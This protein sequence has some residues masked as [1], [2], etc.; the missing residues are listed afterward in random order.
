MGKDK[1]IILLTKVF[2]FAT[3]EEFLEEE[4]G[5]LAEAFPKIFIVATAVPEGAQQTR[6]LP[7][8]VKCFVIN[9]TANKRLKYAKYVV[10]GS[11]YIFDSDVHSEFK[12]KGTKG[13]LGVVYIAGRSHVL[14]NKISRIPEIAKSIEKTDTILYSYWF[15]DLPYVSV[16]LRRIAKN[17]GIKIVSRAHGYDLYEYRNASGY[18]PFRKIVMQNID[19]VFPCSCDGQQYLRDQF[20]DCAEN[21]EVSYLGTKDCGLA[22]TMRNDS[23]HL[24]TCSA[25]IPLKRL[26][27]LAEALKICEENGHHFSWTCIGDG[28]LLA[29]LKEYVKTNLKQDTVTFTGRLKH[30]DVM[31]YLKSNS[32]NL[33]VNVSETEGLPVSIMEAISFGIPALATDVGG[34]KEIV[35]PETTGVLLAKDISHKELAKKLIECSGMTW[36]R[37]QVRAYWQEHFNSTTNYKMFCEKLISI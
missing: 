19:K 18:I 29:D 11:R 28:P 4:I 32:I 7:Q 27:L 17:N 8:N 33:F 24:L 31:D 13:K 25:I 20:P 22:D 15:A 6:N 9:E 26:N 2:P 35:I 16:L 10:K 5:F 36:D 1:S 23:F 34:T 21:I 30:A 37:K 3:G 12:G 14:A